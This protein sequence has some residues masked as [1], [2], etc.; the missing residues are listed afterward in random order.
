MQLEEISFV[1]EAFESSSVA[2]KDLDLLLEQGWRHHGKMFFRYSLAVLEDELRFVIPLRIRAQNFKFSKS[3][4]RILK[5]N[6]DLQIVI[7][8]IQIDEEKKS[9]FDRHKQRFSDNVPES[10]YSF[11]DADAAKVP[12]ESFELAV[13]NQDG[14]LLACSFFVAGEDSI[15][16]IYAMFEPDEASR[17]LGIFTMLLEINHSIDLGKSFYYQGYVYA[18]DSFYDYKKRFSALEQYDWKGRWTEFAED[19]SEDFRITL[20]IP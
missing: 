8:P 18:G 2:K 6:K 19:S 5:Q 16:S 12:C 7:R 1:N 20:P 3:Q 4:K 11:L 14:R 13:Y 17:S 10:I 9:L 15:S